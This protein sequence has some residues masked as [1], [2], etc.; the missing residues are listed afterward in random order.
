[1]LLS[2]CFFRFL[3]RVIVEGGMVI[4]RSLMELVIKIRLLKVLNL[5]VGKFLAKCL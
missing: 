1:M 3:A 5:I 2:G 4:L